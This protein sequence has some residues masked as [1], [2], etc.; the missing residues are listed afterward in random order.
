M[1]F[2]V[3]MEFTVHGTRLA[4]HACRLHALLGSCHLGKSV[5]AYSNPPRG[6]WDGGREWEGMRAGPRRD[7]GKRFDLI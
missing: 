3:H 6:G 2:T 7:Q 5:W 1:G 4:P